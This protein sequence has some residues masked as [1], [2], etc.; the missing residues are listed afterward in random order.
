[1]TASS[2]ADI[3]DELLQPSATLEEELEQEEEEREVIAL[4]LWQPTLRERISEAWHSRHLL[5]G[6]ARSAVP[7]YS[8]RILGRAWHLIRPLWQIF[9]MA[10]I[11][12]GIFHATAPSNVPYLLYVV[13]SFQ[14]FQLFRITLMYETVGSKLIKVIRNLRVPLLLLPFAILNRVFVRLTVYWA[15]AIIVLLYYLFADGKLY[16][17][18]NQ[19]LLIGILG[20]VSALAF[21]MTL[22]LITGV[23]YPRA[24]DVK[25]FV[26]YL[27]P[28]LVFLT[29]VYY[30]TKQLPDWA[31]TLSQFNPLTGIVN[32]V[33]W[34]FL[35][36]GDLQPFA[37]AW[38]FGW[39]FGTGVFGLWFYNKLATRYL[40][41]YKTPE[42]TEDDE[43]EMI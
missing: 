26:R 31:Q 25:Y 20:I 29:P 12:G 16:V 28:I 38:F 21:G 32:M 1:M 11:F 34:G 7:T 36:A 15:V 37:I 30:S 33:Q 9:G 13:F 42:D 3:R 8:G 10:L 22:G 18:L 43:D 39:L 35:D 2:A 5:P 17:Q 6:M 27:T 41:V 23:L 19:R 4:P 24:K 14:A 40:G